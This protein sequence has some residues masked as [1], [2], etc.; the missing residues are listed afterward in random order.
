VSLTE[1][2]TSTLIGVS[3]SVT[4]IPAAA[5]IGVSIVCG[6]GQEALGSFEQLAL[7]IALL[8]LVGVVGLPAQRRIWRWILRR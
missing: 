7:N 5:D 6:N 3:I 8:V 4:T 1:S 2:L